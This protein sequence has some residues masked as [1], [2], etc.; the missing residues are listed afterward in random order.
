MSSLPPCLHQTSCQ[1]ESSSWT[2]HPMPCISLLPGA[3]STWKRKFH[4][5]F[6]E[7][8]SLPDLS[9]TLCSMLLSSS[10]FS[11]SLFL[12][13]T[14]LKT[15]SSNSFTSYTMS[16]FLKFI[17]LFPL[18]LSSCSSPPCHCQIPE[19]HIRL[20]FSHNWFAQHLPKLSSASF[21]LWLF[22][23]PRHLSEHLSAS[24]LGPIGLLLV[25]MDYLWASMASLPL[26]PFF[27]LLLF[28]LLVSSSSLS[29]SIAWMIPS[30]SQQTHHCPYAYKS[31]HRPEMPMSYSF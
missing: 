11:L 24:L 26:L 28:S 10:F 7:N 9:T 12:S 2:Q 23:H 22:P 5:F 21:A 20:L 6:K 8:K 13:Q 27:S 19:S 14:Y 31:C 17:W 4:W 1:Q 18:V 30:P 16:M 29:T 15:V 25:H 3:P